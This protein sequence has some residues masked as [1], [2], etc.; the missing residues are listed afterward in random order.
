[1]EKETSQEPAE[2]PAQCV[3]VCRTMFVR[4]FCP[5]LTP[6]KVR[7][8][9]Q[10]WFQRFGL[11]SGLVW[12]LDIIVRVN[13]GG[14]YRHSC[15][16]VYLGSDTGTCCALCE[17]ETCAAFRVR[18]TKQSYMQKQ[19]RFINWTLFSACWMWLCQS[20]GWDVKVCYRRNTFSLCWLL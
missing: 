14:V 5:V 13:V 4:M 18:L 12:G 2:T 1:M 10:V 7:L 16:C 19:R 6:S 20:S 17:E 8:R 9:I 11:E 15:V 3:C